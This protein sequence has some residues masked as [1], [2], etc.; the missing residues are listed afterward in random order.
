MA[1]LRAAPKPEGFDLRA[2]RAAKNDDGRQWLP[3]DA[4]FDASE[5]MRIHAPE[6][7]FLV[8]WYARAADGRLSIKYRCAYDHDRQAVALA[9]DLLHDL[10][11]P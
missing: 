9:A 10:Q 4:L 7:A 11:S 2:A 3:A 1:D 8:A 6:V 5:Q